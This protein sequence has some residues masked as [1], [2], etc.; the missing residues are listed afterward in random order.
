[1]STVYYSGTEEQ[2]AQVSIGVGNDCLTS[3][4]IHYNAS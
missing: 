2:W 4:T 1:L 3:A